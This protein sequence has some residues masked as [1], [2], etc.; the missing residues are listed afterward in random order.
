MKEISRHTARLLE[1]SQRIELEV[2]VGKRR[3]VIVDI[4][5][6]GIRYFA[7]EAENRRRTNAGGRTSR[8]TIHSSGPVPT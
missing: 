5:C 3:R 1:Y 2:R 4:I 8:G 6:G 7:R